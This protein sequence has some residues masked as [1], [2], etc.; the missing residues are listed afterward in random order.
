MKKIQKLA[1]LLGLAPIVV[2]SS[3]SNNFLDRKPTTALETSMVLNDPDM[4]PTTVVGSMAMFSG[5]GFMGRNAVIGGELMT[6]V[7][8]TMGKSGHLQ[9]LEK[10]N[11]HSNMDE[12]AG[13]WSYCY[14][15][16]ASATQT[17]YSCKRLL[18]DSTKHHLSSA[19]I[20]TLQN[21]I[22]CSKVIRAYC[23]FYL[24]QNFCVDV[25]LA[26]ADVPGDHPDRKVGIVIIGDKPL[27]V[28]TDNDKNLANMSTLKASYASVEKTLEEAIAYFEES[29]TTAYTAAPEIRYF[30]TLCA[31]YVLQARVFLAQHKYDEALIAV[32]NAEDNLPSSTSKNLIN[33]YETLYEGYKSASA[34]SEDIWT[35]NY[36][37]QDNLSANSLQN[38]FG[39][40]NCTVSA[41]I[42]GKFKSG[43]FRLNL[44]PAKPGDESCC[45]KYPNATGVFNVPV[46][47]VPELYLIRAE[48]AAVKENKADMIA[49]LFEILKARDTSVHD[50]ADIEGGRYNYG[51]ATT[52]DA[53]INIVLDERVKEYAGEGY[54]WSDLRRNATYGVRLNRPGNTESPSYMVHFTNYNLA[55]FALPVPFDETSTEQWSNGHGIF[56]DGTFDTHNWQNNAWERQEGGLYTLS[57]GIVLPQEGKDYANN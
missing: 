39:S 29:S 38:F 52:Q 6:D 53:M 42:K 28:P 18:E 3:C 27:G 48:V 31:A 46:M 10:W 13:F 14:A 15:V 54:R 7:A 43:D 41:N 1:V 25:N 37:S 47:R 12:L 26:P 51:A 16:S 8:T 44:Y 22:A 9:D 24:L 55:R 11:I 32:Q 2:F 30:P 34:T 5:Y 33:N 49:A 20:R 45:L 56:D 23:D 35:I 4:A 40:Y 19:Q 50:L 57:N 36:T 21:A 17:S